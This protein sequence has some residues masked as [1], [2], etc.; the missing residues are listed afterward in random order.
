MSEGNYSRV[1][2]LGLLAGWALRGFGRWKFGRA[3]GVVA[4]L[5]CFWLWSVVAVTFAQDR[6]VAWGYVESLAKI[7][8]PFL[9]GITVIDSVREVKQLA[10]VILLSEAY[11]AWEFNLSYFEGYN[12]L[13]M[14]GFGGM[15]NNCHAI[16][17]VACTGL[18][19][20]VDDWSGCDDRR[21]IHVKATAATRTAAMIS[22][23]SERFTYLTQ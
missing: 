7:L 3:R 14:E 5:V 13:W 11:V 18:A 1:V 15:D 16:A 10:W 19:V 8:L 4:A 2:A 22:N 23:G 20:F 17:L 21:R 6:E 12:R 9:V